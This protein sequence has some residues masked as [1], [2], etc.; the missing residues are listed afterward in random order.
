LFFSNKIET[1]FIR[2]EED[3]AK[4]LFSKK[5]DNKETGT[6]K[7]YVPVICLMFSITD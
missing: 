1:Y 3:I 2:E 7:M 5:R 6:Y 4:Y